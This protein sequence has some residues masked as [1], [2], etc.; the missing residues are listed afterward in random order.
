[1]VI[2]KGTVQIK[3]SQF[4][5]VYKYP[6]EVDTPIKPS[7]IAIQVSKQI[8]GAKKLHHISGQKEI[9]PGYN[10]IMKKLPSALD[11]IGIEYNMPTTLENRD[12]AF[13][14]MHEANKDAFLHP[15]TIEVNG[16]KRY[17]V[18][19]HRVGMKFNNI[20]AVDIDND[21][22]NN[23]KNLLITC[24]EMFSY[25]FELRKTAHGYQLLGTKIYINIDDWIFDN[26]RLLNLNLKREQLKDYIK[27]LEIFDKG[28]INKKLDFDTEF[29]KS[30]LCN[31]A[32]EFDILFTVISIKR[33]AHTL[34]ISK[35]RPNDK[36]EL[37]NN[38]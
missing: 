21:D 30:L 28:L 26:C 12:Q 22:I 13:R 15:Q 27:L 31:M 36:W 19:I 6:V 37:I 25:P 9:Y 3:F 4:G 29:K 7:D 8:M 32:G 10:L 14:M 34:R 1:M 24:Q 11:K 17:K 38:V 20:L 16:E 33:K 5:K 18:N 35:K 23:A 2:K